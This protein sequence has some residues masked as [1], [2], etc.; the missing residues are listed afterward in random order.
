MIFYSHLTL[1]YYFLLSFFYFFFSSTS[2][3]HSLS[4]IKLSHL[5]S[6]HHPLTAAIEAHH[7]TIADS[8]SFSLSFFFFLP[9]LLTDQ[10]PLPH[11]IDPRWAISPSLSTQALSPKSKLTYADASRPLRPILAS[12]LY[13]GNQFLQSLLVGLQ[14]SCLCLLHHVML[15]VFYLGFLLPVC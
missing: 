1:K 8:S 11:A 12:L 14:V 3:T 15:R 2:F 7:R 4:Q 13:L 5:S 9:P 6:I 10:T